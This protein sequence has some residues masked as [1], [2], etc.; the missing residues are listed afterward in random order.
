MRH[1]EDIDPKGCEI[2][3][4]FLAVF[5]MIVCIIAVVVFPYIKEIIFNG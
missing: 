5:W 3:I 1:Y 4:I 2:L